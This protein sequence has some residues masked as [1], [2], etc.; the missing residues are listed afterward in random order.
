M[1]LL[2]NASKIVPF[3]YLTGQLL[4]GILVKKSKK[5]QD[6]FKFHLILKLQQ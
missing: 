3:D 2:I 5:R 4:L 6:I 1:D